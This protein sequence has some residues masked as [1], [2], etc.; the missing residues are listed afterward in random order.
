MI[1]CRI[2]AIHESAALVYSAI[3]NRDSVADMNCA[4]DVHYVTITRDSGA[5]SV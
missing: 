3:D 2:N 5:L 4:I 1:L